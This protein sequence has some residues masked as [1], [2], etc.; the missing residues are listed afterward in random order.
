ML[1]VQISEDDITFFTRG[2]DPFDD[3]MVLKKLLGPNP[4]F[5]IVT[6]GSDRCR[7]YSKICF[8]NH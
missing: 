4:K 2:D 7:Y 1:D 8:Q 6:K 3:N 5:L